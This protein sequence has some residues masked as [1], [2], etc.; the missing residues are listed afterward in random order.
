MLN[1]IPKSH[2]LELFYNA[3]DSSVCYFGFAFDEEDF[4]LSS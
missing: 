4:K 3:N 2:M 1:F